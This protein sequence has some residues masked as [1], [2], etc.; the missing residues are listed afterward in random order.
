MRFDCTGVR[1]ASG[2]PC[3]ALF[4]SLH[5]I[6]G[7]PSTSCYIIG[8]CKR[9]EGVIQVMPYDVMIYVMRRGPD[10]LLSSL[11]GPGPFHGCVDLQLLFV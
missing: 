5:A 11:P 1:L 6:C 10:V 3:R 9:R 4:Q 2:S 8:S 7:G